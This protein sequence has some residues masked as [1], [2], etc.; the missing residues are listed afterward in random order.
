MDQMQQSLTLLQLVA[1]V[2]VTQDDG[3][4]MVS[5]EELANLQAPLPPSF[6]AMPTGLAPIHLCGPGVQEVIKVVQSRQRELHL[7][8]EK[9]W[10]LKRRETRLLG[11]SQRLFLRCSILA[12]CFVDTAAAIVTSIFIVIVI[13]FV[14]AFVYSRNEALPS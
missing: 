2:L 12:L 7:G 11:K 3:T 5:D 9:L 4:V 13:V 8:S 6:D 10:K 1:Q 14:F